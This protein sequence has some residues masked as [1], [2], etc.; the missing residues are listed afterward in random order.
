MLNRRRIML[1]NGQEE[2]GMKEWVELL[3][4]SK[5]VTDQKTVEFNLANAEKHEEWHGNEGISGSSKR[6]KVK[7]CKMPPGFSAKYLSTT[8][9]I[10]T[11]NLSDDN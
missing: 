3:N 6:S 1:M 8:K 4:E 10:A 2:D 11:L 5:E 7:Q 9:A